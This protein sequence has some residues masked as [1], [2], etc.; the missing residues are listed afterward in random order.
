MLIDKE[1]SQG[2][3]QLIY[4][5]SLTGSQKHGALTFNLYHLVLKDIWN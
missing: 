5:K 3:N 2:Y 1:G 4:D